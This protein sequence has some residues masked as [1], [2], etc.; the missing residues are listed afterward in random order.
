MVISKELGCFKKFDGKLKIKH[1][2]E[3]QQYNGDVSRILSQFPADGRQAQV[4][5]ESHILIGRKAVL[6]I[7]EEIDT[8]R[9]NVL[10]KEAADGVSKAL[11]RLRE[12]N[13]H[14]YDENVESARAWQNIFLEEMI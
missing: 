7:R 1:I 5:L 12:M 10:R 8:Q 2:E 14:G 13:S 4:E 6:E 11:E 9:N 3:A